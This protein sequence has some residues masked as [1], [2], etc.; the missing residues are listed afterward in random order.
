[1]DGVN[2]IPQ[3]ASQPTQTL[4]ANGNGQT[5][6]LIIFFVLLLVIIGGT[7]YYYFYSLKQTNQTAQSTASQANYTPPPSPT[8]NPQQAIDDTVINGLKVFKKGVLKTASLQTQYQGTIT[9]LN[10][11][12]GTSRDGKFSFALS[13]ELTG[14]GEVKNGFFYTPQ[15]VNIM[16]IKKGGKVIKPADLSVGDSL[17]VI[18]T[19]NLLGDV[20]NSITKVNIEVLNK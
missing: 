5:P 12:G 9:D 4:P 17:L 10:T 18:Q 3:P 13:F 20:A 16:T 1:M 2:P 11:Q 7:V 15:T 14:E 19:T 6:L 8:P